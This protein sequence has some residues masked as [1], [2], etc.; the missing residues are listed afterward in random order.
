VNP[1]AGIMARLRALALLLALLL[2]GLLQAAPRI[3]LVTMQPGEEYWSRFGHNALLVQTADGQRTLYNYG[4]F[5]FEQP[6]F[7]LRFLRGHMLYQLVALPFESDIAYYAAQGRGVHLQWLRL[8]PDEATRLAEFLAW[9]AL[10][11]NAEYRYDYFLDNCATR[12]RDALDAALGGGLRP[13]LIGRSRGL[14]Y[15]MESQRLAAPQGWLYLGI[16]AGLGPFA[17]RVLSRWDE[18]FVPMRLAEGLREARASDGGPLVESELELLPHR[19]TAEREEPPRGSWPWIAAGLLLAFGV[20]QAGHRSSRAPR[21]LGVGLAAGFWLLCGLGGLLLLALWSLTD[22]LAAHANANLLLLSP[23]TLMLLP[24]L[25]PLSRAQRPRVLLRWLGALVVAG[26][27][28]LPLLL[29]LRVLDQDA[30]DFVWLLLPTH[31][32]LLRLL[33]R[34][35][36]APA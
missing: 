26:A 21:K 35:P 30:A 16:H 34:H 12:V 5:D 32:V 20:A 33:W 15:R 24:A 23:L 19:L 36:I 7:L 29:S 28:A 31:L 13:Q 4:F 14:T 11:E 9:N 10:P 2:P 22:H 27:I 25:A 18:G 17:D 8:A 1:Q 3:G 6:G